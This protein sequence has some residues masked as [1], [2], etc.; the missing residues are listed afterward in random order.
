MAKTAVDYIKNAFK[1]VTDNEDITDVV[2]QHSNTGILSL[3]KTRKKDIDSRIT[4]IKTLITKL[5]TQIESE[6]KQ[7]DLPTPPNKDDIHHHLKRYAA[8]VYV[9]SCL[10]HFNDILEEQRFREVYMKTIKDAEE[11]GVEP[12]Y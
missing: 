1:E 8:F 12:F 3:N 5:L 11:A 7:I 6:K 4:T 9:F 10:K 2:T